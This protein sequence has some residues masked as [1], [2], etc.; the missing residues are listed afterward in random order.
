MAIA[1]MTQPDLKEKVSR[2]VF[3]FMLAAL[4]IA[5]VFSI[6]N[7]IQH[8]RIYLFTDAFWLDVVTRFQGPGRFRFLF[9]PIVGLLLGYSHGRR[10]ARHSITRVHSSL[11]IWRNAIRALSVPL[12]IGVL[13][14]VIFQYVL[15]RNI[16]FFPALLIGPLFVTAPYIIASTIATHFG[17]RRRSDAFEV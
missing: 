17:G 1:V 15:F 8:K 11:E 9:Q 16:H 6:V 7:T 4:M 5:A 14:D 10:S 2:V 13:A 3:W 12:M